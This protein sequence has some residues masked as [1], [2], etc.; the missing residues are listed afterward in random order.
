GFQGGSAVRHL[1]QDGRFAV[2]ALTRKPESAHAKELAKAGA[3]VVKAD[4]D[5]QASLCRVFKGCYGVFGITDFFDAFDNEYQ[6]GVNIIDAAKST[7]VKHLVFTTLPE[8]PFPGLM[9]WYRAAAGIYLRTS[10]VPYTAMFTSF[11]YGN[12]FLL[13][14]LSRHPKTGGW[15]MQ[16]PF[17][18]DAKIP[19]VSPRDI[20][21]FVLGALLNP[22][23]WIGK[24]MGVCNEYI[25]PR[26][27]AETYA[28]V[29]G[30]SVEI[31]ETTREEFLA[32]E[33]A[34]YI[35]QGWTIFKWFLDHEDE[36]KRKMST[37][38]AT[39]LCPDKQTWRDY[40]IEH[41]KLPPHHPVMIQCFLT[42]ERFSQ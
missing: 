24:D 10:G 33:K 18:T 27:F 22:S 40:V 12:V 3:T 20:G 19:C 21:A 16:F 15:R 25:S 23:E 13:D 7:G 41:M 32:L 9:S 31:I 38:V 6:Q 14:V 2:R 1:L 11:Y 17:P 4:F 26:Q 8:L 29:T 5:D 35:I 42:S 28:E 37:E 34:P 39:Q 36:S 30:S